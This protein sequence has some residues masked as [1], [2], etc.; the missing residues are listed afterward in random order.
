MR[1]IKEYIDFLN[2]HTQKYNEGN[3][4]ISD[5]EWDEA[6]F[7]LVDL[8]KQTGC[9]YPNS[10]TQ[11]IHYEFKDKLNKFTHKYPML[12]LAK[13]KSIEEVKNFFGPNRFIGMVKM[14]GLSLS[15]TY[16]NGELV[17]ASTR[18]SGTVG[19]DITHNARVIHNIPQTISAKQEIIVNG[20]IICPIDV[21][22]ENFSE[23]YKNPRNFASGSIRLLNSKECETRKLKFVAWDCLSDIVYDY[24]GHRLTFLA[25]Q[26]FEVVPAI[27]DPSLNVEFTIQW[28]KNEAD[29]RNYPIDGIVFRYEDA[30]YGDSLGNTAHHP[31]HSLAFKFADET[32][33]TKMVDII[34]EPSRNGILTPIALFE[35]VE[36]DGSTISR[37][38][39]HNITIMKDLFTGTPW[40]G[41][42][43]W[44][45]KRNMIIPQI[46]C[47]EYCTD[48][49]CKFIDIPKVCPVCGE[50]LKIVKSET[51]VETLVCSN[52][53]CECRLINQ[54]DHFCGK[55]GLDI[56]GLSKA[57][58]EKLINWGWVN[59]KIDIF[60][61]VNY[62]TEWIKKPGFGAKSVANIL[63]AIE[64]AKKTTLTKFIA[65]L[66][67]PFVGIT[68]SKQIEKEEK[69]YEKFKE[70]VMNKS[71][72]FSSWE[73]I[74][75][76]IN[77]ALKLFDYTEADA[78]RELLIM[79]EENKEKADNSPIKDKKFAITG[80]VAF[81]RN[82]LIDLIEKRGGS[83]TS[84][85]SKKTDYLIANQ[86]EDSAKYKNAI[87]YGTKILTEDEV[88]RMID[89]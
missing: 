7:K 51:G 77:R 5:S 78:I 33:E 50:E 73:G 72:T 36:L 14:D 85:V 18:G 84:S 26:G 45:S 60:N 87:A 46:E 81:G 61:L 23:T 17:S 11:T 44:V 57:T 25:S 80:K 67:I 35:P 29:V 15:L 32:V 63:N 89:F 30:E 76:E 59:S 70:D 86:P 55:S 19:E 20:E 38:S 64:N 69:T 16:R 62:G 47:A 56:K 52:E 43:I 21:F 82:Q 22:N 40:V 39:V 48:S 28:L 49:N 2:K 66:G 8:E 79:E 6:Y 37:A 54:L 88:L 68:V 24:F 27:S 1:T 71:F 31:N 53:K 9:I 34:Y 3:P 42:K 10:P 75:P 58:L 41:Q 83:V 13:T 65:S 74:G 12:S 4:E